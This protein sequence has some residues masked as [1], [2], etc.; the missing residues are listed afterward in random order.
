MSSVLESISIDSGVALKRW[1]TRIAYQTVRNTTQRLCAPLCVDDYGVQTIAQVS[2]PKWHLA[3]TTWFFETFLLEAFYPQYQPFH[4]RYRYLFNSYYETLGQV[5]PRPQR[6]W[7]SRPCV[8]DIFR[9]RT[10]V[11]EHLI[12]LIDSIKDE[13][14]SEFLARL[15]LGIHHEQQH[16]EL[17]LTDIKHILA[18]NPLRP[19]YHNAKDCVLSKIKNSRVNWLLIQGGL[20]KIG[21]QGES[22][23]FDNERPR[24][25]VFLRDYVLSPRLVTNEEYLEFIDAGIYSQPQYWLA[26]GWTDVCK[27]A[28]K[29][30]LYWENINGEWWMMTLSGMQRL[31]AQE[32]V[33]HVSYYEADAYA[34]WRGRRLP[35]EAEWEHAA[36]NVEIAGNL[37]DQGRYHPERACA[38]SNSSLAQLFG[39]VW[40]W[41]CSP[42]QAY[43][44]YRPLEGALGEYNG[45]FMC[46]QWVLRGGSCVTPQAHLRAS[47]RN[48]FYPQDRWQFTGIRLAEYA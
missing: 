48:F 47:Y 21:C 33:C 37:Q 11:D 42:Y 3:H 20:F 39:D 15:L 38:L 4:P 9:Y 28:W 8:E 46:N 2:P 40:E 13:Y 22:F 31:A 27:G 6:G 14:K 29:A 7:L 26:D 12:D 23:A 1:Q 25:E 44:G 36:T 16:Q 24:H 30:P 17:L 45:K 32:P 41:T 10:Y 35:S 5:Y 18:S 34:R 19:A 43:P